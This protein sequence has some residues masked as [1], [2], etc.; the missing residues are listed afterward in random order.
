M[1]S[2]GGLFKSA[3]SNL[4]SQL[5]DS[6]SS[7]AEGAARRKTA[8]EKKNDKDAQNDLI[9]G[10]GMRSRTKRSSPLMRA[11]DT[12]AGLRGAPQ[13]TIEYSTPVTDVRASFY[14]FSSH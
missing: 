12:C 11:A 10:S 3:T 14:F 2:L 6:I 8:E 1:P 9:N 13:L 4:L 7:K 5:N